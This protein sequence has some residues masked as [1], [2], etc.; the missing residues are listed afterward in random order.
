MH[1]WCTHTY[2]CSP[3]DVSQHIN[4]MLCSTTVQALLCGSSKYNIILISSVIVSRCFQCHVVLEAWL[5]SALAIWILFFPPVKT[6][7]Q[8]IRV[9]TIILINPSYLVKMLRDEVLSRG[10]LDLKYV[11]C[12]KMVLKFV[13]GSWVDFIRMLTI[14]PCHFFLTTKGMY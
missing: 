3:S 5:V 1:W 4:R 11:E 9:H 2:L 14:V 6:Q 8:G 13:F 7:L 12:V 10:K